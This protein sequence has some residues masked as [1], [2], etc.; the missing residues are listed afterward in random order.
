MGNKLR[1][2]YHCSI[3]EILFSIEIKVALC[4]YFTLSTIV[5]M[6]NKLYYILPIWRLITVIVKNISNSQAKHLNIWNLQ[7]HHNSIRRKDR[8]ESIVDLF[9]K[10]TW[11]QFTKCYAYEADSLVTISIDFY[12]DLITKNRISYCILYSPNKT[13]L[14]VD[15]RVKT[16][17][18]F[19]KFSKIRLCI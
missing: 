10:T 8:W 1:I 9:G 4:I 16:K 5:M 14:A 17:I 2:F 11:K 6:Q 15:F 19:A 7:K 3:G 12:V 18:I 13:E